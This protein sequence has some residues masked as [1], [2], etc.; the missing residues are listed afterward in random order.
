MEME[1]PTKLVK[2][3]NLQAY[4]FSIFFLIKMFFSILGLLEE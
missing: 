4:Q 1:E 3:K 2:M